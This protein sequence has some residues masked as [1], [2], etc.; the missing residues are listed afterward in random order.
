MVQPTQESGMLPKVGCTVLEAIR[1]RRV[2]R[3]LAGDAGHVALHGGRAQA[4]AHAIGR[5]ELPQEVGR[6]VD[7]LLAQ[8]DL[9]VDQIALLP[10]HDDPFLSCHC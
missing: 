3:P 1:I 10:A 7:A 4:G 9:L 5:G 8:F 2:E 6:R